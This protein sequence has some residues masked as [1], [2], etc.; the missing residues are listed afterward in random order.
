MC[1]MRSICEI[2]IIF[3][4]Y[5]F[6]QHFLIRLIYVYF[7]FYNKIIINYNKHIMYTNMYATNKQTHT[8]RR[9][10]RHTY[11]RSVGSS[12]PRQSFIEF[13][14]VR[15]LRGGRTRPLIVEPLQQLRHCFP[16]AH[17]QL[18][19][20][21]DARKGRAQ[22]RLLQQFQLRRAQ[23]DWR[24]RRRRWR[25]TGR[26]RLA[27][28]AC[29]CRGGDMTVVHILTVRAAEYRTHVLSADAAGVYRLSARLWSGSN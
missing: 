14:R 2:K 7:L 18:G 25:S 5:S 20:F 3:F 12:I 1:S 11:T 4:R 24:W 15:L 29:V 21:V 28:R 8:Y 23:L 10:P 17:G 27:V 16:G 26:T 6:S 9:S 22:K 19:Q 13:L